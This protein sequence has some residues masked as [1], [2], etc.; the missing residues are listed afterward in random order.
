MYFKLI[1]FLGMAYEDPGCICSLL[2]SLCI[3][4][5]MKVD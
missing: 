5:E 3:G 1:D 2:I 4:K